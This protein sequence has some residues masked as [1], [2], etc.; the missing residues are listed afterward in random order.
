MDVTKSE[1]RIA[2]N[3]KEGEVSSTCSDSL[4]ARSL[5][6]NDAETGAD[7]ITPSSVIQEEI[8][9]D[10]PDTSGAS[11]GQNDGEILVTVD[12]EESE[13]SHDTEHIATVQSQNTDAV[14]Q[15]KLGAVSAEMFQHLSG[16]SMELLNISEDSEIVLLDENV[17]ISTTSEPT[18]FLM[19]YEKQEEVKGAEMS[20]IHDPGF[21]LEIPQP[22]SVSSARVSENVEPMD[23]SSDETKIC[24]WKNPDSTTVEN[25]E[26]SNNGNGNISFIEEEVSTTEEDVGNF[27]ST[28]SAMTP[29]IENVLD[30]SGDSTSL[31]ITTK[32]VYVC[33][34]SVQEDV[35]DMQTSQSHA[36][37]HVITET[38]PQN[39]GI[40]TTSMKDSSQQRRQWDQVKPAAE[41][42]PVE[43]TS[44]ES[45]ASDPVRQML[46]PFPQPST[47]R[48][49]SYVTVPEQSVCTSKKLIEDSNLSNPIQD[50]VSSSKDIE[51]VNKVSAP[52]NVFSRHEE[53]NV[54]TTTK[55]NTTPLLS[56]ALDLIKSNYCSPFDEDIPSPGSSTYEEQKYVHDW[57]HQI[58]DCSTSNSSS[59]EQ[60]RTFTK[61]ETSSLASLNHQ[62]KITAES[63]TSSE[64][65]EG[66]ISE[67][68]LKGDTKISVTLPGPHKESKK[69]KETLLFENAA[70]SSVAEHDL[71]LPGVPV[72]QS[73]IVLS[74]PSMETM[75]KDHTVL[76]TSSA[77]QTVPSFG[78]PSVSVST[79]LLGDLTG[80]V[81]VNNRT[82]G[83]DSKALVTAE[84]N[85]DVVSTTVTEETERQSDSSVITNILAV[86]RESSD[87]TEVSAR[88]EPSCVTE[89]QTTSKQ[90][91]SVVTERVQTAQKSSVDTNSMASKKESSVPAEASARTESVT[92]APA[93]R[94]ECSV[95]TEVPI[96]KENNIPAEKKD[97]ETSLK[98]ME[99]LHPV[100]EV[101]REQGVLADGVKV[102]IVGEETSVL[103]MKSIVLGEE[104][105]LAVKLPVKEKAMSYSATITPVEE[106]YTSS[107]HEKMAAVG[108]E[109]TADQER[110]SVKGS[111][112]A[113]MKDPLSFI[114]A[115]DPGMHIPRKESKMSVKGTQVKG[116]ETSGINKKLPE[117]TLDI[118]IPAPALEEEIKIASETR[119]VSIVTN[120]QE[121]S[122]IPD[123][124]GRSEFVH[125]SSEEREII[126]SDTQI[127]HKEVIS[128]IHPQG[129]ERDTHTSGLQEQVKEKESSTTRGKH[130]SVTALQLPVLRKDT[131]TA[132]THTQKKD[133]VSAGR[134]KVLEKD[135]GNVMEALEANTAAVDVLSPRNKDKEIIRKR[136]AE[137][138]AK[139]KIPTD[140][141]SFVAGT[142]SMKMHAVVDKDFPTVA[143]NLAAAM[144]ETIKKAISKIPEKSDLETVAPKQLLAV[145]I[146]ALEGKVVLT[147]ESASLTSLSTASIPELNKQAD[148]TTVEGLSKITNDCTDE[149]NLTS[150]TKNPS[151]SVEFSVQT[152]DPLHRLGT[153]ST[154]EA[155]PNTATAVRLGIKETLPTK[156]ADFKDD[157]I[158]AEQLVLSRDK[159]KKEEKVTRE[160]ITVKGNR[161]SSM[162]ETQTLTESL[163]AVNNKHLPESSGAVTSEQQKSSVS[164]PKKQRV[165]LVR[166]VLSKSRE[167]EKPA[168]SLSVTPK[169]VTKSES[170]NCPTFKETAG[171]AVSVSQTEGKEIKIPVSMTFEKY[172]EILHAISSTGEADLPHK[173]FENSEFPTATEPRELE[174]L[175][176]TLAEKVENPELS[177]LSEKSELKSTELLKDKTSKVSTLTC[178][179]EIKKLRFPSKGGEK[180]N[181]F[182][183]EMKQSDAPISLQLQDVTVPELLESSVTETTEKLGL[184]S[185]AASEEHP[186]LVVH[187]EESDF[188]SKEIQQL[189]V[190]R[191][192]SHSKMMQSSV[193]AVATSEEYK[194]SAMQTMAEPDTGENLGQPE[195]LPQK[196]SDM[197]EKSK[198]SSSLKLQDVLEKKHAVSET[199]RQPKLIWPLKS[200]SRDMPEVE[201]VSGSEVNETKLSTKE[202]IQ[203]EGVE[204]VVIKQHKEEGLLCMGECTEL[205]TERKGLEKMLSDVKTKAVVKSSDQNTLTSTNKMLGDHES[206]VQKLDESN[207][208]RKPASSETVNPLSESDKEK[209]RVNLK[210]ETNTEGL[211]GIAAAPRTG[212]SEI[213][214][215]HSTSIDIPKGEGLIFAAQS[216]EAK[217]DIF[218]SDIIEEPVSNPSNSKLEQREVIADNRNV[219]SVS[220][221]LVSEKTFF[222][223][224][225][226]QHFLQAHPMVS[227]TDDL[228]S[229]LVE[230]KPACSE[231]FPLQSQFKSEAQKLNPGNVLCSAVEKE[232]VVQV[233]LFKDTE[234]TNESLLSGQS[235]TSSIIKKSPFD[236]RSCLKPECATNTANVT[237]MLDTHASKQYDK[238]IKSELVDAIT[239][240]NI[241]SEGKTDET[242][243]QDK[244]SLK[245]SKKEEKVDHEVKLQEPSAE[246][247]SAVSTATSS[248][249]GALKSLD[250][251]ELIS[252][253]EQK[254]EQVMKQD[255]IILKIA[256]DMAPSKES[257][258]STAKDT[259]LE[260]NLQNSENILKLTTANTEVIS[261][262]ETSVESG[263]V[264]PDSSLVSREHVKL[265][266]LTLK[267]NKP[268]SESFTKDGTSL[269]SSWTSAVSSNIEHSE[270]D[271]SPKHE[272]VNMKLKKDFSLFLSCKGTCTLDNTE[273]SHKIEN[274]DEIA[275]VEKLTL[276]LKKDVSKPEDIQTEYVEE[277]KLEKIT[278][279]F[280]LDPAHRD[281]RFASTSTV[282]SNAGEI[283]QSPGIEQVETVASPAS[284]DE[285]KPQKI[286]LKLKKD[287]AKQETITVASTGDTHLKTSVAPVQSA[288][289]KLPETQLCVLKE[290][291][292]DDKITQKLKKVVSKSDAFVSQ[293]KDNINQE[294]TIIPVKL[295]DGKIQ[296][297]TTSP[298][299]KEK[300]AVEKFTLKLRKD[301]TSATTSKEDIHPETT[302]T[303]VKASEAKRS[304][305]NISVGSRT[306]PLVEKITLKLKKD[307]TKPETVHPE[308]TVTQVKS[309]EQPKPETHVSFS[310]KEDPL[311]EK[312]TLKLKKEGT[313]PETIIT[314][315]KI[316]STEETNVVPI[317]ITD[318]RQKH[319][320]EN[321]SSLTKESTLVEK[322]TLKIKKDPT[323]Q[324]VT[325]TPSKHGHTKLSKG[326]TP[327]TQEEPKLEK[328]TLKLKK[329]TIKSAL[330]SEKEVEPP[331]QPDLVTKLDVVPKE[332]NRVE[333]L[334]LK[335]KK[336]LAM[337]EISTGKKVPEQE[338]DLLGIQNTE[339]S[340]VASSRE[341]GK[342]EKLTLKF[343]K[344]ELPE[345][346][347]EVTSTQAEDVKCVDSAATSVAKEGKVEKITLKL[348]KDLTKSEEPSF[349]CPKEVVDR[350]G[351]SDHQ[352]S[353]DQEK[354]LSEET[355]SEAGKQKKITLT[356][357]KDAAWSVKRN[358]IKPEDTGDSSKHTG[359]TE[360]DRL[361]IQAEHH[362][363]PPLKRAK[364]EEEMAVCEKLDIH[365]TSSMETPVMISKVSKD[366]P[367]EPG[368]SGNS[369]EMRDNFE[370]EQKITHRAQKDFTRR[371]TLGSRRPEEECPPK[372]MRL[373]H[374]MKSSS[375]SEYK[376]SKSQQQDLISQHNQEVSSSQ[377]LHSE[378]ENKMVSQGETFVQT[379]VEGKLR[380]ILS[381]MGPGTSTI[382]SGDL[383]ISLATCEILSSIKSPEMS[384]TSVM[385]CQNETK[386]LN[387]SNSTGLEGMHISVTNAML[388]SANTSEHFSA[389]LVRKESSS[390]DVMIIEEE[391]Q[392]NSS[393][394]LNNEK[395]VGDGMA[396]PKYCMER[397]GTEKSSQ[398]KSVE[399]EVM[400]MEPK[401]GRGRPRKTALVPSVIPVVE[402]PEQ[403]LRPKR[404]C[405]GR[406]RP[407]VVVKVRKPRVGKGE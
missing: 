106:M 228:K 195:L 129:P 68:E 14:E 70:A 395:I 29:V 270:M 57:T 98:G 174:V 307:T 156:P 158:I 42:G 339:Q 319:I 403:I 324:E 230:L 392:P 196:D 66:R 227:S 302:V 187:G 367:S 193:S 198:P 258:S 105:S 173:G 108:V 51:I 185:K 182:S 136:L 390:Q 44:S 266:K 331:K 82:S 393:V 123:S 172:D 285:S 109:D 180:T 312:I 256:K 48:Q 96:G 259:E 148:I 140:S 146:S 179:G 197:L 47:S 213:A 203:K 204:E 40:S 384:D 305:E 99:T 370:T 212:A 243:V 145:G 211:H 280:K 340:V 80:M 241:A 234:S 91:F 159:D 100:S 253:S 169:A 341:E 301:S 83:T 323:K 242:L 132:D 358:K 269:K 354:K 130:T 346:D 167:T 361:N 261:N 177:S 267:P 152:E 245:D 357:K 313:K 101:Q 67:N 126:L 268:C 56:S 252:T 364:M 59:N 104:T 27:V 271:I 289:I 121:T 325:P 214:I 335:L 235:G 17:L 333:K 290:E 334:T 22:V 78:R 147:R 401:K 200:P 39:S 21:Q 299:S 10:S 251:K 94:T 26:G 281:I 11:S 386:G 308:T 168:Y 6:N 18:T 128:Y 138:I 2:N 248:K 163:G 298:G 250:I 255:K 137:V 111:L 37:S 165:K 5:S 396:V 292:P 238:A 170:L 275:K 65:F 366:L 247:K 347:L 322:I 142:P 43:Q 24:V 385:S 188:A 383:S 232:A 84:R 32:A 394:C 342:V 3:E 371:E 215:P 296:E 338:Y 77:E 372:K 23:I 134:Q 303:R 353:G 321:V 317:N 207:R 35:Q 64:N 287:S 206:D 378:S 264:S 326:S 143:E 272:N 391:N 178:P 291:A 236:V 405:R 191:S 13:L 389:L 315:S 314:S 297:K 164:P 151:G 350:D 233:C 122:R 399:T 274:A 328:L 316:I 153:L 144:K 58:G 194:Y 279:K 20:T 149:G 352:I 344:S 208:H 183:A 377:V 381:K 107:V 244:V 295:K 186:R 343:K 154:K 184:A 87:V 368:E 103:G 221:E 175:S 150:V 330:V 387:V 79:S 239:V 199:V 62:E 288:E 349:S 369:M 373:E 141:Y 219:E 60:L 4:P 376:M 71:Q 112:A 120:I 231:N 226:S 320:D 139:Q 209:C 72:K 38:A 46:S 162:E 19:S 75:L 237:L 306:E 220:E 336:D 404:M 216:R 12:T 34:L 257:S 397:V 356:L 293:S 265:E 63:N 218:H 92:E 33:G 380:E 205:F 176:K 88:K 97:I 310:S 249:V 355:S 202:A 93:T 41:I 277:P 89:L 30:T 246:K 286:T 110:A 304:N 171:M 283:T 135:S 189:C 115:S 15:E 86:K 116:K 118:G 52:T 210:M 119:E 113:G 45:Q 398:V 222:I 348:R 28:S 81:T 254:S 127:S 276:K 161:E 363:E 8:H 224:K 300:P 181:N 125:V 329:D 359:G 36:V 192:S 73:E 131:H 240:K 25:A 90:P 7:G 225:Q 95:L 31:P 345:G 262:L 50:C 273:V 133:E 360:M 124:E 69:S 117:E 263:L 282:M 284:H 379:P 76:Y 102:S 49:E 217:E 85:S 190:A 406:E 402:P 74:T 337:T 160:N 294:I 223:H 311:V 61:D 229:N 166:P 1:V 327:V 374:D 332:E 157:S 351:A 54:D 365:V 318:I 114:E 16:E 400:K 375:E 9:S 201:T 155:I 53:S 309:T 55:V 388:Q 260:P 362:T 278:L 382:L 407:P